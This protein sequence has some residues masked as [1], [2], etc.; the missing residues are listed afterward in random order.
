MT[1]VRDI[2]SKHGTYQSLRLL[3][4]QALDPGPGHLDQLDCMGNVFRVERI[5]EK[6]M[7]DLADFID[8]REYRI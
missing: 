1:A 6:W 5:K 7:H 2:R 3:E 4:D 8:C